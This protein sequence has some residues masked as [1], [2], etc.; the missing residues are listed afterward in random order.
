M[1]TTIAAVALYSTGLCRAFC[2]RRRLISF[3]L[4]LRRNCVS[5]KKTSL[6]LREIKIV[7]RLWMRF[8]KCNRQYG[9]RDEHD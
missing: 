3:S 2:R 4:S 9:A 7:Q 5:E 6:F 8:K 1:A